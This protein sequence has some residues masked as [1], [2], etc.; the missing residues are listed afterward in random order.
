MRFSAVVALL[1]VGKAKPQ[2]TVSYT[3]IIN[4]EVLKR[5]AQIDKIIDIDS[6][7][8]IILGSCYVKVSKKADC[9]F[10]SQM[11][12]TASDAASQGNWTCLDFAPD[13]ISIAYGGA[14]WW[15]GNKHACTPGNQTRLMAL[16]PRPYS[17]SGM[18]VWSQCKL[19]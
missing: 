18:L 11:H 12:L 7:C 17:S 8:M 19:Y 14:Y 3:V 6:I 15:R 9:R 5:G 1:R 13:K 2:I 16:S 4:V 10:N